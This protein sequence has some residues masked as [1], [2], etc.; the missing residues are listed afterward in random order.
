MPAANA[1]SNFQRQ[2][3]IT[4]ATVPTSAMVVQYDDLT[5]S[6]I[7]G[8]NRAGTAGISLSLMSGTAAGVRSGAADFGVSNSAVGPI[9][10]AR[11][12]GGA[13]TAA[14]VA[15]GDVHVLAGNGNAA[16]GG[17]LVLGAGTGTVEGVID[18]TNARALI[19]PPVVVNQTLPS[20][21]VLLV[22]DIVAGVGGADFAITH[23]IDVID[24]WCRK[25][26]VPGGV[27]TLQVQT[28]AGAA[29]VT[30]VMDMNVV[31]NTVVRAGALLGANTLFANGATI[32]FNRVQATNVG[33]RVYLL[34]TPVDTP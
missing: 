15:G 23:G 5:F 20:A 3:S 26:G 24:V 33:C 18:A 16:F 29:N 6:L 10:N 13:G 30:D 25:N 12:L 19:P 9:Q 7:G 28:A 11:V 8:I 4:D 22:F 34:G 32:R 14:G 1:N 31:A 27:D 17:N 21:P 2:I